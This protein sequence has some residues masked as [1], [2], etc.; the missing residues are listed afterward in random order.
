MDD[1]EQPA[2]EG[3]LRRLGWA[4][5]ELNKRIPARLTVAQASELIDEWFSPDTSDDLEE[6]WQDAK[7]T[8]VEAEDRAF[9][10][11]LE[12][13]M[14]M[15][16][17]DVWRDHHGCKHVSKSDIQSVQSALGR[18]DFGNEEPNSYMDR[19]FVELRRQKPE[20]FRP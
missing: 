18:Y 15:G 6:R 19:F 8:I 17:L 10:A 2:T 11:G 5:K 13:D 9:A 12:W 4:A 7:P 14:I 16:N 3:Q 20:L 1:M